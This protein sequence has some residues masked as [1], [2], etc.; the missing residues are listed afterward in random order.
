MKLYNSIMRMYRTSSLKNRIAQFAIDKPDII[1]FVRKYENEIQW[2]GMVSANAYEG[3]PSRAQDQISNVAAAMFDGLMGRMTE[4][5]ENSILISP[6]EID[7]EGMKNAA[8]PQ[9]SAIARTESPA[10]AA[11]R[12]A[13]VVNMT[14]IRDLRRWI[15]E[16]NTTYRNSPCFKYMVL[17][18]IMDATKKVTGSSGVLPFK[19]YIVAEIRKQIVDSNGGDVN[20]VKAYRKA[21]VPDTSDGWVSLP[22]QQKCQ[23]NPERHGSF[24]DNVDKLVTYG[25]K[26]GWCVGGRPTAISYLAPGDFHI[27]IENNDSVVGIM[28]RGRE[29]LEIAGKNNANLERNRRYQKIIDFLQG[30]DD[31]NYQR[32]SLYIELVHTA[33]LNAPGRENDRLRAINDANNLSKV[34]EIDSKIGDANRNVQ[35]NDS[36][37]RKFATM[38]VPEMGRRETHGSSIWNQTRTWELVVLAD[39]HSN[40]LIERALDVQMPLIQW[41][42]ISSAARMNPRV[43]RHV[44]AEVGRNMNI[45]SE[46]LIKIIMSDAEAATAM[47]ESI[48][49]ANNGI[50]VPYDI[51][52]V[53]NGAL[54]AGGEGSDRVIEW[55]NGI[56]FNAPIT[57]PPMTSSGME[58]LSKNRS[59]VTAAVQTIMSGTIPLAIDNLY[60]SIPERFRSDELKNIVINEICGPGTTTSIQFLNSGAMSPEM[61]ERISKSN[62]LSRRFLNIVSEAE[63]QTERGNSLP[64]DLIWNIWPP[65][66]RDALFDAIMRRQSMPLQM[67]DD[68]IDLVYEIINN[69]EIDPQI[70]IWNGKNG[71]NPWPMWLSITDEGRRNAMIPEIIKSVD[72][73]SSNAFYSQPEEF[74]SIAMRRHEYEMKMISNAKK[75]P[76]NPLSVN[77]PPSMMNM[78][79]ATSEAIVS[80]AMAA[81]AID[82]QVIEYAVRRNDLKTCSDYIQMAMNPEYIRETQAILGERMANDEMISRMAWIGA[83]NGGD[84]SRYPDAVGEW[85]GTHG[86]VI[87]QEAIRRAIGKNPEGTGTAIGT[88]QPDDIERALRNMAG[89]NIDIFG[90]IENANHDDPD[91]RAV[92]N[93]IREIYFQVEGPR[94]RVRMEVRRGNNMRAINDLAAGINSG[95]MSREEAVAFLREE[96]SRLKK[97]AEEMAIRPPQYTQEYTFGRLQKSILS[98]AYRI[99]YWWD[100]AGMTDWEEEDQNQVN[101][102]TWI[103]RA[104]RREAFS[105]ITASYVEEVGYLKR[106]LE[107]GVDPYDYIYK[108]PEFFDDNPDIAPEDFDTDYAEE[109]IENAPKEHLD[110]FI[111]YCRENPIMTDDPFSA[112]SYEHLDYRGFVKPTWLVHFTDEPWAIEREGFSYGHDEAYNL[113]LTTWKRNRK[114]GP[115]YNFSFETGT[116][117]AAHKARTGDYGKHAVVFFGG[118]VKAYHS[119]D[120][121]HQIIVWGPSVKKDMIF[122]IYKIDGEWQVHNDVDRIVYSGEFEDAVGWIENNYRMLQD[123]RNKKRR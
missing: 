116:R 87:A 110:R 19:G 107:G 20:F 17:K 79:S 23:E 41:S 102:T 65:R 92:S 51:E 29:I 50:F 85:A 64:I 1:L 35:V 105:S 97:W 57:R 4:R 38:I 27:L 42:V 7:V 71:N 25:L 12:I 49:R 114:E 104:I 48:S 16:L 83:V 78:T 66:R 32:N 45:I 53:I 2:N 63:A 117:D 3:G 22:S 37:V 91:R 119:G 31:L 28:T 74:V 111:E 81:G 99:T 94:S 11:R 70:I 112:P 58:I 123:T 40:G 24:E 39:E 60:M 108:L 52:R 14:R 90:F 8:E 30:R 103:D 26:S 118:G 47:V 72:N 122:P 21:F 84:Y 62:D 76:M 109:W 101:A 96:S 13:E 56:E 82:R 93:A 67:F 15:S 80:S 69:P 68:S 18:S 55:V 98:E 88:L 120:E 95:V 33:E 77:I 34:L 115:G 106:Y 113:G 9:I 36:I 121:E 10:T 59:Y 44:A 61:M 54:A 89:G 75:I 46:D 5:D 100:D 43:S 6:R 73:F 86:Y